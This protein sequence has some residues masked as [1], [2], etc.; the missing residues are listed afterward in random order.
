MAQPLDIRIRFDPRRG[1]T[2][3]VDG[4]EVMTGNEPRVVFE[5]V[6]EFI[7]HRMQAMLTAPPPPPLVNSHIRERENDFGIVAEEIPTPVESPV[8]TCAICLED[9]STS[10]GW[11]HLRN[12]GHKFH[13]HCLA[14]WAETSCPLC[15]SDYARNTR[16]RAA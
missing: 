6:S 14:S 8:E 15:R 3:E 7:G 10:S 4:Q 1:F 2:V 9:G 11:V 12:C 16:H 13:T 5:H